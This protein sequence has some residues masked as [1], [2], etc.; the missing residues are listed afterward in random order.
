MNYFARVK[1]VHIER[2]WAKFDRYFQ[3]LKSCQS[4]SILHH[5]EANKIP[6]VLV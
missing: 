6:Q 1:V 3:D 4:N 2:T 5:L